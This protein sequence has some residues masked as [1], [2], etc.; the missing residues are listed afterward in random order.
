MIR[1]LQQDNRLTKAIFALVIGAAIITMVITLVPGIFDNGDTVNNTAVYAKIR[2]P[3]FFGKFSGDAAEVKTVD[4]DRITEQQIQQQ[5]YPEYAKPFLE[6]RIAQQLVVQKVEQ[7][8][9]DRLGLAV[10]DDDLR[11]FLQHG[12]LSQYLF[13]DG[14]FIGDPT[15]KGGGPINVPQLTTPAADAPTPH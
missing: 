4:V 10:S 1:I 12:T 14:K 5:H 11:T 2:T 6:P 7:H 8:E 13:P 9:A 15:Q 3:G